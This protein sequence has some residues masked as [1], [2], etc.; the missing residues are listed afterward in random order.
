[1]RLGIKEL[2]FMALMGGLLVCAY[3]F[4]FKPDAEKVKSLDAD[5]ATKRK[6]LADLRASTAGIQDLEKKIDELQEAITFFESK[7]PKEKELDKILDSVTNKAKEHNLVTKSFKTG[8]IENSAG[9]SEQP[10][11]M[12][13]HGDF[14]NGFYA[15]LLDLEKLSRIT[16][17]SQ[18]ELVKMDDKDG[19]MTANLTLSIFF[20]RE[21]GGGQM[22]STK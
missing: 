10:I 4:V 17:I 11:T 22:A 15:F 6:A 21:N 1:M 14:R 18:M 3:L 7:L 5:S 13:L 2:I 19:E 9:Y 12:T 20:E 16:R 8:K